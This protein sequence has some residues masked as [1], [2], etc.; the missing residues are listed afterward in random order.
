MVYQKRYKRGK[1]TNRRK[2]R[3]VK[4]SRVKRSRVKRTKMRGGMGETGPEQS[5]TFHDTNQ[6][7]NFSMASLIPEGESVGPERSAGYGFSKR[8]KEKKKKKKN[9]LIAKKSN[10]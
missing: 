3:R 8:K 4:R 1:K 6:L 7:H 5:T 2:T 10:I 9:N